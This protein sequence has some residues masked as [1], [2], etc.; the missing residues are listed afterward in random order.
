MTTAAQ[1]FLLIGALS[2]LSFAAIYVFWFADRLRSNFLGKPWRELTQPGRGYYGRG[3]HRQ[4]GSCPG[5]S[6][7]LGIGTGPFL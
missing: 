1:A 3:W 2:C 7:R 5:F 4:R 6:G